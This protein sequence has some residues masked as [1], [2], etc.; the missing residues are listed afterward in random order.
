MET[1]TPTPGGVNLPVLSI[2][3]ISRALKRSV[4][5]AFSRVRVRGEI[6]G[7]K[8]AASGHLYFSLKDEDAVLDGVCWRGTRLGMEPE[9][10]MEVIASGRLSTYAPRSRYQMVVESMELAGEGA[11]L[12][13]LEERKKKLAAEGMFDAEL[14]RPIPFLPEV[15]GVVTSPTGAVIRDILHRLGE[16]FPRRVLLWPVLVQGEAAAEQIATAIEG[17]NRLPL[18]PAADALAPVRPDVII[19]ARGGGSLEDLW[20]FNEER[21]VRAARAS[22]IPLISAVGHETDTTLID[23]AADVRAPTPSAAAEMAVPVRLDLLARVHEDGGRMLGAITRLLDD[24]RTRVDGLARGLPDLAR[25]TEA[26]AQRLDDWAERLT[27]GLGVGLD[28]R[29]AE[30]ARLAAMLPDLGQDIRHGLDRL[31]GLARSL[32][33]AV[34]GLLRGHESRLGQAGALLESASYQRV[35]E[36]GFAMVGDASGATLRSIRAVAVGMDVA[37]HFHDGDAGARV[38]GVSG[39][40]GSAG[41]RKKKTAKP[42][43][44]DGGQGSLL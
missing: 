9:D 15:I 23:L 2:S 16:R 14:K 28:R 5:D 17:F 40:G 12:K 31:A 35:L 32:V 44:G 25:L 30:L 22:A 4:E 1:E 33:P 26:A 41:P 20:A 3:E 34:K 36:R 37:L 19:V 11:L 10:G 8:R 21:V 39:G 24:G 29:R 42:P 38:I 7:F 43:P 13:L 18:T 6:T 27:N